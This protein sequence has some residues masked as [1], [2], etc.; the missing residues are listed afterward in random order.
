MGGNLET[1]NEVTSV[2]WLV[3]NVIWRL[4]FDRSFFREKHLIHTEIDTPCECSYCCWSC[5]AHLSFQSSKSSAARLQTTSLWQGNW[6]WKHHLKHG[7]QVLLGRNRFVLTSAAHLS[8]AALSS[9]HS[10]PPD[11]TP[12]P[13]WVKQEHF[14]TTFMSVESSQPTTTFFFFSIF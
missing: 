2:K 8:S 11:Q 9:N 10:P 14:L 3:P 5:P 7:A 13:W 12:R 1:T 6:K 4:P